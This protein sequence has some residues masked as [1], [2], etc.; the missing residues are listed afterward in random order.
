MKKLDKLTYVSQAEQ[1]ITEKI[2]KNTKR[3]RGNEVKEIALSTNKIR[4]MLTLINELYGMAKADN[5]KVLNEEIQSRIQYTKMKLVYE[6][7]RDPNVKDLLK[8]SDLLEYLDS[9]GESKD[10]LMLVCKYMEALVAYHKFYA[11][12]EN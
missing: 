10:A 9:V 7:G 2:R 3:I 4:N 1:V 8:C 12:K 11:P 5:E 6:A